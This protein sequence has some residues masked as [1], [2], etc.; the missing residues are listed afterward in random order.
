MLEASTQGTPLAAA[1]D[2]LDR[3][4]VLGDDATWSWREVHEASLELAARLEGATA[5]CNLC[6]SRLGF[7]VTLLAALRRGCLL[8]LPPSGGNAE[9]GA[10]VAADRATRVVGDPP[11]WPEPW[12]DD[13]Y[14][15]CL[16]ARALQPRRDAA[17]LAWTPVWD[18]VAIRLY[19]SG[20]TGAPQ[21]QPKTLGQLVLGARALVARL[22]EDIEGGVATLDRIVCS[23][24]PQHMFGLECSVMLPLVC[25]LPVLDRRPL[26]PADVHAAFEGGPAALWVATPM[27]LRSLV[28][29]NEAVPACGLAIASTMPLAPEIALG[30]ERCLGAPVLEIYGSTETGALAMRRTSQDVAWR[31]LE[32]V[33]LE[34]GTGSTIARGLHFASPVAV[35]DEIAPGVDG[36]F[37]LLGRHADLVKIAGRRASLAGLDRLLLDLPGI[38]DGA[39]YLPPTGRS[40]ERLCLVYAGPPL[41]RNAALSWLRERLDPVFL[42]RTFI[43][44]ERL[45]RNEGGKLRRAALARIH[46][47]WQSSPQDAG[48]P[49]GAAL[50]VY[51]APS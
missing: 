39:F 49:I 12:C 28:Q 15:Q 8:I 46:E 5:V 33:R 45:P 9:L 21:A 29:E 43:R 34:P 20:S 6:A 26:L 11:A 50:P 44:V 4:A 17:E 38:E 25:G 32:G 3:P 7:L 16:P 19:T 48:A 10:V 41:D 1:P 35:P 2:W 22:A 51:V 14:L 37:T 42:P 40:T 27:H 24:P 13:R 30:A 23:V 18:E 36:R 47:A 31:P